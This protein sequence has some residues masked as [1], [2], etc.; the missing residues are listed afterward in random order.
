[1]AARVDE[2]DALIGQLCTLRHDTD[3][4]RAELLAV[5]KRMAPNHIDTDIK[6]LREQI[7]KGKK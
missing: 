1:L 2:I 3:E 5:R 4:H 6:Y 7:A